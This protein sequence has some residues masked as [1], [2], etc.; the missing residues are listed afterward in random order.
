MVT[1]TSTCSDWGLPVLE[2]SIQSLHARLGSTR[3]CGTQDPLQKW[4]SQLLRVLTCWQAFTIS[5]S[6]KKAA[7]PQGTPLQGDAH[8]CPT[9]WPLC[10]NSGQPCR[11]VLVSEV[12][13]KSAEASAEN[14]STSPS[15]LTCFLPVHRCPSQDP[16]ETSRTLIFIS[17]STSQETSLWQYPPRTLEVLPWA[18]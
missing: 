15:A 16:W 17:G 6:V 1:S 3:Q 14:A 10:F 11:I 12:L 13:I 8:R 2:I 9:A 7:V 18:G 5:T 4:P